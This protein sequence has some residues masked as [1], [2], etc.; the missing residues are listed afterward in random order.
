MHRR[1][2]SHFLA[3]AFRNSES[4][5][6][7]VTILAEG[8]QICE[9]NETIDVIVDHYQTLFS[10]NGGRLNRDFGIKNNKLYNEATG[11]FP[12]MFHAPGRVSFQREMY[13]LLDM[14]WDNMFRRC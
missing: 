4:D 2:D 1:G 14:E 5:T 6:E 11:S 7:T 3:V 13:K 10:G 12:V 8:Q 9:E